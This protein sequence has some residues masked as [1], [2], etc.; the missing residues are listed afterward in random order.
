LEITMA[1]EAIFI[2]ATLQG[3]QGA[4]EFFGPIK[5]PGT[6]SKQST[7]DNHLAKV[8]GARSEHLQFPAL[9]FAGSVLP[10]NDVYENHAQRPM[11]AVLASIVILGGNGNV[12]YQQIAKDPIQRGKVALP[13]INYLKETYPEQFANS[14]R[15]GDSD[16]QT[17]IF[18]FNLKQVLRIAAFEVLH[19]NAESPDIEKVSIP[20]RLW[21]NPTGVYDPLDVLLPSSDRRD[22]DLYSLIRYFG[23]QATP[24]D[25]ST[26]SQRQ[27]EV[28]KSLV[29]HAQLA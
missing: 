1:R 4:E 24:E 3:A 16:P 18:G 21:H 2:G 9:A 5:V 28:A 20:V 26:S 17:S 8:D 11:T 23:I 12:V 13:L 19:R 6:M 7:I 22:L 27:A 10:N 14:L 15:Y 29:E 25:L